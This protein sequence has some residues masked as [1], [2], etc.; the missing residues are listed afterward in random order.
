MYEHL[1]GAAAPGRGDYATAV[2]IAG[3]IFSHAGLF[4]YGCPSLGL[5]A[6]TCIADFLAGLAEAVATFLGALTASVERRARDGTGISAK[7]A[8]YIIRLL[9]GVAAVHLRDAELAVACPTIAQRAAALRTADDMLACAAS[10]VTG[11]D[12]GTVASAAAA[13]SGARAL[14]YVAAMPRFADFVD[15][16]VVAVRDATLR[17]R[18]RHPRD[19]AARAE[20]ARLI[21][22]IITALFILGAGVNTFAFVENM[23]VFRTVFLSRDVFGTPSWRYMP[24]FVCTARPRGP[25][26]VPLGT[27]AQA[28][29]AW[30][31][32]TMPGPTLHLFAV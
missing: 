24:A 18:D 8:G 2:R 23:E 27:V 25:E 30:L 7:Q 13:L 4:Q 10:A 15:S 11:G 29:V 5:A 28:L 6:S 20:R 17:V 9:R 1:V 19:P 31:I 26:S 21:P 14:H 16:V 22:D 12:G 3:R 32:A